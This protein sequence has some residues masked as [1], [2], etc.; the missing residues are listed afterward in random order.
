LS[1]FA[2]SLQ[3]RDRIEMVFQRLEEGDD[4]ELPR[5]EPRAFHACA[6]VVDEI[7][8]QRTRDGTCIGVDPRRIAAGLAASPRQEGAVTA[9]HVEQPLSRAERVCALHHPEAVAGNP[10]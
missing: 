7:A 9:A 1:S 3:R 4:V 10:A 5:F 8:I 6:P 2:R